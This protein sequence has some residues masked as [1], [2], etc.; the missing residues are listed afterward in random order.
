LEEIPDITSDML[1]RLRKLNINSVYQLAVQI[2]S[3]LAFKIGDTSIDVESA[4]RL[5]GNARKVLTENDL[6]SKEFSTADDMLEKRNEISR[7]STGSSNFD[8]FL[9]GG[10]ETRA[11]T[12]IAG[13][14]GSGKSQ[15]CQALCAAAIT[16][17]KND[18]LV[19]SAIQKPP[20]SIIFV[21]TENTFR[22][23]RI[24][25]IAEQNN[26]DPEDI[27]KR[28]YH[29]NIYSSEQLE[30]LIDDLP[31]FIEE[32]N[33]K[34]V[35]IDSIISL[36]RAEFSGRGTLVERQQRLGRMLNKLRKYAEVYNIAVVITNQV[37]SYSDGSSG[38]DY[39]KAAGGNI[40]A[41]SSTY[42]IFLKKVG[43]NRVAVMQDSPYQSYQRVKF[44]I[45]E[46]GIQ[47]ASSYKT[48]ES[49]SAW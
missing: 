16:L 7:Y 44:T 5:I 28:I 2:P 36:H 21:D 32:Y 19:E 15:I 8:T 46:S 26:L 42:R 29:C 30:A 12:E 20:E 9:D 33:S 18:R 49:D 17:M 4:V 40:M 11:I 10:F 24:H 45:T 38:F 23:N 37:V 1:D 41:H 25:Q 31:N 47:D 35:I 6:L 34:L 13:E 22:A 14:F 43:K 39:M 3:E 48:E 27:L